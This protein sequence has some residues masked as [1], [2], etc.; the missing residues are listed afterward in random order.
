MQLLRMT[1]WRK[2]ALLTLAAAATLFV[3]GC[4]DRVYVAGPPP[5]PPPLVEQAD[6]DG[7]RIGFDNGTRDAGR[8][9]GYHP[10]SDRAYHDTPGYDPRF[11]PFRPYQNNFRNAYLRGYNQAFNRR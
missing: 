10:R 5:G 2:S 1:L 11:G 6:H 3:T 9:F 4:A 8:G 7:F